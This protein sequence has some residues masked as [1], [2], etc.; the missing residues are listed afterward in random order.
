VNSLLALS[1]KIDAVSDWI[2]RW[3]SWLILLAVIVSTVNAVIRKLFDVSSNSW[4]E[5][6]WVLFGAVFLLCSPWTLM[7]NEHIRIDIVNSLLPKGTR[8]WID[9]LGH[10]LFLLPLC[11]IM[12]LVSWP[13][14]LRSFAINEQSVNAG[15]LAQWPA[16]FLIPIGF[17]LLFIQGLS[18]LIKR[19]AIISG[20][21]ADTTSGGG[22]HAA[23]EAEAQRLLAQVED[24][25]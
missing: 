6:Q 3:M 11:V 4:L 14:A 9:V 15:G 19:L 7:S 5:L 16:K 23:A 2:G 20:Q 25:R 22:H 17:T 1:R 13:F 10:V 18:E 21:L 24:A 12:M 8:N